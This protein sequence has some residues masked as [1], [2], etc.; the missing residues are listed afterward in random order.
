MKIRIIDWLEKYKFPYTD[1]YIGQGKPRASAYIDDRAVHCSPQTDNN[2]F[3][4]ALSA[5]RSLL[6]KARRNATPVT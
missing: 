1:V 6:F 3:K 2:A 4:S 5:T